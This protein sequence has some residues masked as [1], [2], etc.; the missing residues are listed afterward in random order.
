VARFSLPV[1]IAGL[2]GVALLCPFASG[3]VSKA[4]AIRAKG[5]AWAT[6]RGPDTVTAFDGATGRVLATIP[7]GK[8][9]MGLAV[10]RG[11]NKLYV[12][13]E[14][15]NSVSVISLA[16][17]EVI[18]TINVGSRPH[19]MHASADGN[20]VYVAEFGTNKI[21][22]IDTMTDSLVAEWATGPPTERTHAPAPTHDGKTV[23][24][25]NSL[26]NTLVALDAHTGAIEWSM[27]TGANPSELHVT[28]DSRTG[29]LSVRNDD[30]VDVIDLAARQVT[31][32][33]PVGDQPDTV[34]LSPDQ[35]T[36]VVALRGTPAEVDVINLRSFAVSKVIFPGER[37]AGH[38]W[39]SANGRY[40]FV[41]LDDPGAVGVIDHRTNSVVATWPYPGGGSVHG[42]FYD[43]P[44]AAGG[45]GMS[46]LR[47]WAK[48]GRAGT[49]RIGVRCAEETVGFCRSGG[50][51]LR[52][53]SRQLGSGSFYLRPGSSAR[54]AVKLTASGRKALARRGRLAALATATAFDLNDDRNSVSRRIV[55]RRARH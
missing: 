45:P 16:R 27:P 50:V 35:Q 42:M 28:H 9:P 51:V 2:V 43:D 13:N 5:T 4:P 6:S 3:G 39:L 17:R 44:R 24:A 1:A 40:T 36:L 23:Y 8:A 37:L 53:G 33:I 14:S 30:E 41:S 12:G 26:S 38:N 19:H 55:L 47:K 48:V 32:R 49:A 52:Q 7:V 20:R 15:S 22:V 25:V 18:A 11:T 21:G 34:Q 46:I 29:Y 54:V 31:R 10:P